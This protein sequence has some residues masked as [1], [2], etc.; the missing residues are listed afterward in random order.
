[1]ENHLRKLLKEARRPDE[2]DNRNRAVKNI[3]ILIELGFKVVICE[4]DFMWTTK[5]GFNYNYKVSY[6]TMATRW[7][8]K[9]RNICAYT[10]LTY[11][12]K[13]LKRPEVRELIKA[14]VST[15][16]D[17]SKCKGSG[18]IPQFMYYAEG[19]CFDC[20]GSGLRFD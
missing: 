6:K 1:M 13:F 4:K 16:S 7:L 2:G 14:N 9:E 5:S 8:L 15:P 11:A 3:N 10:L 19:V 12:G 17:C 20:G 18:I